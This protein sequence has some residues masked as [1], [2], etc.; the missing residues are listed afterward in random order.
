MSWK[1]T[2]L[3]DEIRLVYGKSLA[4][5]A[6]RPGPFAVYG[7]NGIVG[8]HNESLVDGPG[9]VIGRKGSVGAIAFSE[10]A[11]W[12]IDTTYYVENPQDHDWRFLHFLLLS[13][14]LDKLNSHSTI[15][16]L[17]RE[18]AYSV[19]IQIPERAEQQR[20]SAIFLKVQ[21]AI[22]IEEKLVVIN[23]ELKKAICRQLFTK[24]LR[25]TARQDSELGQIPKNWEV[26]PL[27]DVATL[28]RGRFT[29]R[30][31]NDP[32]FYGGDTPFVQTG[33]I[34][35]SNGRVTS[36]TQSLNSD[37]VAVSKV[38]P[39]GTILIT[40][41]ANIGFTGIL[42]FASACPDSLVGITPREI[43][44]IEYLNFFLQTQRARMDELAPKGTQKNINIEFLSP[45]PVAVPPLT[46]Q[47]EIS[48]MLTIIDK[49]IDVH[50]RRHAVARQLFAMLL[51]ELISRNVY[52]DQ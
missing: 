50:T 42:D 14:G 37:G 8:F 2:T 1:Q 16:G 26:R 41:A 25:G 18:S 13:L 5:S 10:S 23:R 9:L 44:D 31:R 35:R 32:R 52:H 30:P 48:R 3:R 36:H 47:L 34:V 21:R 28:A 15:P 38:F 29:H 46:E 6:R 43:I 12:P 39:K 20:I 24:G 4:E 40:I 27:S 22:E 11:F 49:A 7:S 45:W 19:A 33:D 17:N 51:P